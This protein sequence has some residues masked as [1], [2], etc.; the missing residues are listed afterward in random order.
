MCLSAGHAGRGF[1]V[2]LI[3]SRGSGSERKVHA[4]FPAHNLTERVRRSRADTSPL[5]AVSSC[6][7]SRPR[8]PQR[9][10]QPLICT[11]V[12]SALAANFACQSGAGVVITTAELEDD[13]KKVVN[14]YLLTKPLTALSLL[15]ATLLMLTAQ[16]SS[17]E[18]SLQVIVSISASFA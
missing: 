15:G 16:P 11:A 2:V 13:A 14:G 9:F 10:F 8:P 3:N 17:A 4:P 18:A 5:Q 6:L 12:C 7:T 1:S